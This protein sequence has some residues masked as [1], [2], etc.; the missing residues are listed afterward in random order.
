VRLDHLLSKEHLPAKVG[1][2]PVL[3]ECGGGVLIGGDTGVVDGRQ[4][5]ALPSTAA[6]CGVWWERWWVGAADGWREDTLLSPEGT[7]CPG[8]WWFSLDDDPWLVA[9]QCPGGCGPSRWAGGLC[10]C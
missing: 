8:G 2:E 4:R 10:V 9:G 1:E 6:L 3:P 5:L 7:T